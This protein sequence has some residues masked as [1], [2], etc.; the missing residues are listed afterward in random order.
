MDEIAK[1]RTCLVELEIENIQAVIKEALD[2]G[3]PP[4]DIALKGLGDGMKEIGELF[5]SEEYYLADLVL[6]GE[7]MKEGMA[8]LEPLMGGE[9]ETQKGPVVV[10]TVKGDI[11]DIGKNLVVTMLSAAGFKVIDLGV[12]VPES[13]VVE[14]LRESGSTLV[15]MSVLI[16]PMIGSI[17]D[18]VDAISEAGLRDKVKIAIGGACTTQE[19]VEKYGLDALG[20]DAV[21]A[22]RIFEEWS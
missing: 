21:D 11:H 10:F 20:R 13:K 18:I 16:T 19:I 14:A 4:L 17:G 5:Q 22:V 12:D 3:V 7:A 15:G 1:V 8:V 6:A 9:M 2:A